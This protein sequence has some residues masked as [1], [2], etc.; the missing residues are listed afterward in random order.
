MSRKG[1]EKIVLQ[2]IEIESIAAEGNSLA[3]VDGKVLFVP[4]CIPG[5]VVDVRVHRKK[6]GYMEGVAINMV[7]PS[8]LRVAPFCD[9]YG[10]CGGCKWQILPY[11]DQIAFKQQQVMDQLT[12]IGKIE[13]PE[14]T[15]ILGSAKTQAY[16][17]KVEFGFANKRWLTTEEIAS[18]V[19]YEH[20][21]AVGYHTSGSFDKI[22]PIEECRLMDDV[23]NSIRNGIRDYAYENGLSF[24]D[25]REHTG[26]LR[27]MMIRLSNTGELMLLIAIYQFSDAVQGL[28]IS[29]LR[30]LQDVKIIMPIVTCSYLLL[31]IPIGCLL[32]YGLDM[33][34]HGL[35]IGLIIGLSSAALLTS[36]R[37]RHTMRHFEQGKA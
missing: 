7:K 21:E 8:P 32:A 16:R 6:S 15:P 25:Q 1:K 17:N 37:L 2:N 26:L 14:C 29:M 27:G 9:H 33:G 4:L 34:C 36:L 5:D 11:E 13:L 12:R 10:T 35:A 31:N 20:P 23:N 22:L 24:Y 30:G 19:K 3:R 18:G 28:S